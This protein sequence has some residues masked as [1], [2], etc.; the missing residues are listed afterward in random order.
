MWSATRGAHGDVLTGVDDEI[1]VLA[2]DIG[3]ICWHAYTTDSRCDIVHRGIAGIDCS[4]DVASVICCRNCN[5][6]VSTIDNT[7]HNG[8][9]RCPGSR[10]ISCRYRSPTAKPGE[11]NCY[12]ADGIAVIVTAYCI[13]P[14]C[15]DRIADDKA[16]STTRSATDTD[17][18]ISD[19]RR[20]AIHSGITAVCSS[21]CVS[22]IISRCDTDI[23]VRRVDCTCS[24]GISCRPSTTAVSRSYCGSA[25]KCGEINR[26]T[27]DVAVVIS[28]SCIVPS[29]SNRIANFISA[30]GSSCTANAEIVIGHYWCSIIHCCI[31]SIGCSAIA[32]RISCSDTDITISSINAAGYYRI[33]RSPGIATIAC[34]Y[35]RTAAKLRE[36][37][38][39][40]GNASIGIATARIVPSSG[41]CIAN[42]ESTSGT[43]RTG[44][45]D[46]TVGDSGCSCRRQLTAVCRG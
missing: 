29:R 30:A 11:I 20:L 21:G 7:A 3:G 25:A 38:C 36:I 42:F 33:S 9:G 27:T 41:N 44:N 13:V 4:S 31:G 26:C 39:D 12:G 16:P 18:A 19:C 43:T 37:Y 28:T 24:D 35:R 15:G 46:I 22:C 40:P 17:T 5:I 14:G 8:I 1:K 2:S 10:T 23:K 45:T 34:N 6:A 32:T